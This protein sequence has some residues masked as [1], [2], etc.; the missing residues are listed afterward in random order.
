MSGGYF[1]YKNNDLYYELFGYGEGT[2]YNTLEDLEMSDLAKDFLDVLHEF[3]YYKSGD[4]DESDYREA[5]DNF[6][7]KWIY[8][9][10]Q[11][12]NDRIKNM[13]DSELDRVKSSLYQTFK[14]VDSTRE[15]PTIK[16][17]K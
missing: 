7:K 10:E 9:E 17:D 3:D 6:K 2:R 1:D 13:I 16:E 4:T 12:K 14:I 8:A 15:E 5:V 11:T